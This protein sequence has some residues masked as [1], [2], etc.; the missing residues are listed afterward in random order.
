VIAVCLQND[1]DDLRRSSA[2]FRLEGDRLAFIPY[3]PPLAKKLAETKPYRWLASRSHLLVLARFNLIDARLYARDVARQDAEPP[4]ALALTIYRDF[5]AD[6]K[7]AGAVPVILLLPSP[8]QIAQHRGV[9][10]EAPGRSS[11]ILHEALLRF[12]A[13]NAVTCIDALERFAQSDVIFDELFIPGDDHFSA[14]GH[15]VIADLLTEPLARVL[16]SLGE[17]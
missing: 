7:E 17:R 3:K 4:L 14:T 13:A 1:L 5:I 2:A 12:C 15:R 16:D 9:P 8:D 10:A 11:V 6:V